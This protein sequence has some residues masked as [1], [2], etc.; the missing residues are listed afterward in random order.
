[1]DDLRKGKEK[2]FLIH[3]SRDSD[4]ANE[5]PGPVSFTG[6]QQTEQNF[7]RRL[8]GNTVQRDPSRLL[9]LESPLPRREHVADGG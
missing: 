6:E 3:D 9:Y 2:F 4:I 7:N 8:N 1:M 5:R